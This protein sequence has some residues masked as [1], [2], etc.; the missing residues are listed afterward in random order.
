MRARL[1][2]GGPLPRRAFCSFL[3][4]TVA[5]APTLGRRRGCAETAVRSEPVRSGIEFS[6]PRAVCGGGPGRGAPSDA[7]H[8]PMQRIVIIP[9]ANPAHRYEV[10]IRYDVKESLHCTYAGTSS[11]TWC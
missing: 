2:R 6:L 7:H 8:R 1:R 3:A 10:Y 4:T 5:P 9:N 11:I